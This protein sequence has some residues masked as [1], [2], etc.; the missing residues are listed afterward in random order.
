MSETHHDA[1]F[2]AYVVKAIVDNPDAV[3][4]ERG[5]DERGVLVTL[6][7][8]KDDMGVVIGRDGITAKALRTLLRVVGAKA[9]ARVNLKINEPEGSDRP[10]YVPKEHPA[11][12]DHRD[13]SVAHHA[14]SRQSSHHDDFGDSTPTGRHDVKAVEESIPSLEDVMNDIRV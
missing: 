6:Q 11:H 3:K 9:D 10:A 2:L 13:S 7:V 1:E 5:I 8:H 4:V 14:E 12:D